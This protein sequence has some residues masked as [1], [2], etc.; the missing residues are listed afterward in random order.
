MASKDQI[1]DE[2]DLFPGF[3]RSWAFQIALPEIATA[4]T[5]ISHAAESI[6]TRRSRRLISNLA[7]EYALPLLRVA[8][9]RLDGLIDDSF[10]VCHVCSF[11]F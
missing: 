7:A 10:D 11:A 8:G 6:A 9:L 1:A 5:T 4:R 3:R 2:Q